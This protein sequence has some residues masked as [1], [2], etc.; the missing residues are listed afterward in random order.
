MAFVSEHG[1]VTRTQLTSDCFAGHVSKDRLDFALDELLAANPPRLVMTENR[2][3]SGRPKKFYR[4]PA[5]N[6][7][8]ANKASADVSTGRIG[9]GEQCEESELSAALTSQSRIVR[10][11]QETPQIIATSNSSHISHSTR[12]AGIANDDG[13]VSV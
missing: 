10:V 12:R 4:L 7:S 5:N 9:A 6:A 2:S 13:E 1:C 3:G 8:Y 11:P